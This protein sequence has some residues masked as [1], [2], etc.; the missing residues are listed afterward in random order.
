LA[1]IGEVAVDGTP[2][3]ND[4][5]HFGLLSDIV[6][7]NREPSWVGPFRLWIGLEGEKIVFPFFLK[8]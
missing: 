5:L 3:V 1:T 2:L 4:G 8:I 6:A 7:Q